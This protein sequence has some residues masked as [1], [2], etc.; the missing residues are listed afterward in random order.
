MGCAIG[1]CCACLVFP[2]PEHSNPDIASDHEAFWAEQGSNTIWLTTKSGDECPALYIKGP[3]GAP[4]LTVLFSHGNAEDITLIYPRFEQLAAQHNVAFFL[5]EYSGYSLSTG[6]GPSESAFYDNIEA[7][8]DHLTQTLSVPRDQ[9][10]LWGRSIGSGPTVHLAA[11]ETGL[12]G[13]LIESGLASAC[14]FQGSAGG[15][16]SML[17]CCG[18]FD[19]FDNQSKL[20][21]VD[22]PTFLIHGTADKVVRVSNCRT[23]QSRLQQPYSPYYAEGAG[24]NDVDTIDR[25][26][27]DSQI[28]LF[29][30]R[31]MDDSNKRQWGTVGQ[32]DLAASMESRMA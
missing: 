22:C 9:V 21:R 15:C 8:F 17:C 7:A 14:R 11:K 29:F 30:S 3:S 5:Y 12:A 26:E 19:F 28:K 2:A 25:H 6:G 24:H 16:L 20:K 4:R 13:M 1:K 10:V 27:Y 18:L 31:M 32:T 23:N